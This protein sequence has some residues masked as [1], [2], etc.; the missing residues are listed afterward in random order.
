MES[1]EEDLKTIAKALIMASNLSETEW[2]NLEKITIESFPSSKN[3]NVN[4]SIREM[5]KQLY[6]KVERAMDKMKIREEK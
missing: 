5:W 1:S 3:E 2:L 6:K 4:S